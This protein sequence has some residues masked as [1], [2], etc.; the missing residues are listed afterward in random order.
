M[1]ERFANA[2]LSDDK[3]MK[4]LTKTLIDGD[5][6]EITGHLVETETHLGRSLLIDPNALEKN[7]FRQVD[8]RTIEHIIYKNVKYSVGRKDKDL[9]DL[10]LKKEPASP[11]WD[12][13]K[14]AVGNWFSSITY[15]KVQ[16]IDDNKNC[17]VTTSR[18]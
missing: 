15:F 11:N 5:Q 17:S 1:E 2:N 3:A 13:N 9:G 12:A 4:A 16:S 18:D 8:L 14:L 6:C 10:P 7:N